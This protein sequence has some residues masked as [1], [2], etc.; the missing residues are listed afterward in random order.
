MRL[1]LLLCIIINIVYAVDY[2]D[3]LKKEVYEKPSGK[4][5]TFYMTAEEEIW[6]YAIHSLKN[7]VPGKINA[8]SIR[9]RELILICSQ[10]WS[11]YKVLQVTLLR[12]YRQYLYQKEEKVSVA[13]KYGPR[14]ES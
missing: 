12:I 3:I 8:C 11:W 10:K 2:F 4:V 9:K 1:F 14:L 13:R 6:D 7:K 5:R